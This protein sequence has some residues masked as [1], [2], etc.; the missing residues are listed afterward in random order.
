M[1]K[2][3]PK[4]RPQPPETSAGPARLP[5]SSQAAVQAGRNANIGGDVVGRDKITHITNAY[6]APA[7]PFQ[8]GSAPPPP[9]VFTGR[10]QDLALL[11]QRLTGEASPARPQTVIVRGGPGLGKTAV[12]RQLAH[13]ADLRAAFPDG[14]LWIPL[15]PHPNLLAAMAAAGRALGAAEFQQ[16]RTLEEA[17]ARLAELLHAR[18]MLILIDDAWQ[19]EHASPFL[20]GGPGCAHLVTT[21]VTAV[22]ERLA[23]TPAGLVVLPPLSEPASLQL[24]SLLADRVVAE[25]PGPCADLARR[26]E[27]SPLGLQVAGRLLREEARRGFGVLELLASLR[28]GPA[29]LEAPAPADRADLASETTP[30]VAAVLQTSI[31]HLDAQ[32]RQCFA[33]LGALAPEPATF[34][35]PALQH[36]WQLPEPRPILRRL[37]DRGILEYVE[38]RGRYWMH[39]LFVML[40]RHW[41]SRL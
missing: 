1:A 10:D 33:R 25:Q 21:R 29:L 19:A 32:A 20:A 39:A 2:K 11:K 40:A 16:A 8:A 17:A 23:P 6:P 26:L 13:E 22:A 15:T 12:A 9:A 3:R 27:G 35:L 14:V 38:T 24:L 4:H 18:R 34:D 30:T 5:A 7:A 28:D 36:L 31:E 41:L 37:I